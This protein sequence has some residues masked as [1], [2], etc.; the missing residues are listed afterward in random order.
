MKVKFKLKGGIPESTRL[1]IGFPD[2][3]KIGNLA[4]FA[5]HI[6]INDAPVN[7]KNYI[8]NQKLSFIIEN[9]I[10]SEDIELLVLGNHITNPITYAKN[11]FSLSVFLKGDGYRALYAGNKPTID[12]V[13]YDD[14]DSNEKYSTGDRII[15]KFYKKVLISSFTNKNNIRIEKDINGTTFGY[16]YG[17]HAIDGDSR[18]SSSF[19]ITLG[20]DA[21]I[22][23]GLAVTIKKIGV[24]S[25]NGVLP[26]EDISFSVP[27]YNKSSLT[28]TIDAQYDRLYAKNDI[29]ML[30]TPLNKN[31]PTSSSSSSLKITDK[32]NSASYSK[33][34]ILDIAFSSKIEAIKVLNVSSIHIPFSDTSF[35]DGFSI[36]LNEDRVLQEDFYSKYRITLGL[37]PKIKSNS[38]FSFLK[39]MVISK[40][41]SNALSDVVFSGFPILSRP[42]QSSNDISFEDNDR[43]GLYSSNDRIILNFDQNIEALDVSTIKINNSK[44]I[45][46]SFISTHSTD[47]G[48]SS[49]YSIKLGDK[50]DISKGDVISIPK[51]SIVNVYGVKAGLSTEFMRFN[52]IDIII[53]EIEDISFNYGNMQALIK[54]STVIYEHNSSSTE[55]SILIYSNGEKKS[56]KGWGIKYAITDLSSGSD[57]ILIDFEDDFLTKIGSNVFDFIIQDASVK[58]AYNITNDRFSKTFYRP[59]RLVSLTPNAWNLVAIQDNGT[60]TNIANILKTGKV[61]KIW[62]F[63]DGEWFLEKRNIK[64]GDG[65]WIVPK[66]GVKGIENIEGIKAI[67]SEFES[68]Q[69][70]NTILKH[71]STSSLPLGSSVSDCD[72]IQ[73]KIL[74]S[75]I[76]YNNTE[77]KNIT[78][79]LFDADNSKWIKNKDILPCEGFLVSITGNL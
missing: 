29:D 1:E 5:Q 60:D 17:F 21:N 20:N 61:S 41:G 48:Y 79:F 37:N 54:F 70:L 40:D 10:D 46:I 55:D 44:N 14:K 13:Y 50:T 67:N 78:I 2:K 26:S 69:L 72:N 3:F 77:D 30:H 47:N 64:R 76:L 75:D 66:S 53:P 74:S 63:Y 18:Y 68:S 39:D 49:T 31:T 9:D 15:I 36:E 65:F 4:N 38:Q 33:G 11:P 16:L 43:N 51:S 27:P 57:T 59:T 12:Q 24:I 7:K 35:G 6:Y 19:A 73:D 28:N 42:N 62:V 34:D 71:N 52:V 23:K 56:I 32:D 8:N 45:D 22:S 25:E 58:S